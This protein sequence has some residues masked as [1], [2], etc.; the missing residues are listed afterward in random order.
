M[1]IDRAAFLAA[2]PEFAQTTTS[3]V[4]AALAVALAGCKVG[5]FG[6]RLDEAVI[7]RTARE[8][9]AGPSGRSVRMVPNAGET[10]YERD[11]QAISKACTVGL[12]LF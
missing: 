8:L 11:W 1:T 6:N 2:K 10:T 3:V 4:D 12:R 5:V 9:A 7:K